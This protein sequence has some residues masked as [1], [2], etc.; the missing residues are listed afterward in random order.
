MHNSFF[1]CRKCLFPSTKPDLHFDENQVCLACKFTDESKV[2]DFEERA[3]CFK[4][5]MQESAALNKSNYDCL[6]PV[7]GGKD[8]TYQVYL[9][10]EV[11]NLNPLLVAFEPSCPTDVGEK[12]LKN[13]SD[14]F[15]CDLIQL[16]KSSVYRK[17]AKIGFDVVGD[18]E[19]PNHVGIYC[20][21]MQM[22]VKM[23]IA[24]VIYGE[25]GGYIGQGRWEHITSLKTVTKEVV[26][27]FIGMNGL[28]L[29]D[30]LAIDPSI[31]EKEVLPYVYPKKEEIESCH[32]KAHYLGYYFPWDFQENIKIIKEYGWLAKE[33]SVEGTFANWEDLDCGFMPIHQYMKFVKYGYARATD[34][35]AYEIRQ[36]RMTKKQAIECI[37]EHDWRLPRKYFNEFLG[38]LKISE[39]Y[40]YKIVDRYANP[41][42]FKKNDNGSFIRMW[43]GN[44]IL[45]DVWYES[46][47][48][49]LTP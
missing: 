40:F 43:D 30:V 32:V 33:G 14:R 16:R 12:N 47:Q 25:Q 17:L 5:T 45:N 48:D 42:L 23:K 8:S 38:F 21:P 13:L 18:H 11:L 39:N 28:R 35:A 6:I 7:S 19:W 29:S 2:I 34:H 1:R 3:A 37:V 36:G 15:A 46:L 22:A 26:N 24:H 20:W 9:I 41:L 49:K 31:T 44:L 27:H 4:K 10:K